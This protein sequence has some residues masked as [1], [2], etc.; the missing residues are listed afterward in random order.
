M[1]DIQFTE[2]HWLKVY[3]VGDHARKQVK[4]QVRLEGRWLCD[5]GFHPENRVRVSNPLE[6]VLVVRDL[7][8]KAIKQ[9]G[10]SKSK[11]PL[12]EKEEVMENQVIEKFVCVSP[13][14][15]LPKIKSSHPFTRVHG[16][17]ITSKVVGVSF[18]GRQET[19]AR[20]HEGDRVWL[21]REVNNSFD[22]NAIAVCRSNGEKFGY[23]NRELAANV[24]PYFDSYGC[25]VKGKVAL[26]IGSRRDGFSLGT[27]ITFKVPRPRQLSQ[28]HFCRSCYGFEDEWEEDEE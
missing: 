28:N 11:R 3:D 17:V 19:I 15:N 4:L 18:D 14:V 24:A 6:G 27:V 12:L 16:R 13:E 1:V 20:L 22:S 10:V 2:P 5:A 9:V 7:G 25:P 8:I 26:Q 21:E 23:L